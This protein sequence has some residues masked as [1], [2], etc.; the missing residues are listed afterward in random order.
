MS[1]GRRGGTREA[2]WHCLVLW[3]RA[4][5][6]NREERSCHSREGGNPER[7]TR[8]DVAE[9]AGFVLVR[10]VHSFRCVLCFGAKSASVQ[11]ANQGPVFRESC[12]RNELTYRRSLSFFRPEGPRSRACFDAKDGRVQKP[13]FR[14]FNAETEAA[15]ELVSGMNSRNTGQLS[16]RGGTTRNLLFLALERCSKADFSRSLS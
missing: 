1:A 12:S 8:F 16:F 2:I 15:S 9:R 7:A 3:G 6:P 10:C 11:K 4:N 5:A 13:V 14:H